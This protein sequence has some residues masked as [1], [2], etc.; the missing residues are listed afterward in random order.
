MTQDGRTSS[1]LA[2]R[3]VGSVGIAVGA[4]GGPQPS[5]SGPEP[6]TR[7]LTAQSAH[8][9]ASASPVPTELNTPCSSAR[10]LSP[11]PLPEFDDSPAPS[12]RNLQ[13]WVHTLASPALR[14]RE[15]G[16]SDSQRTALLLATYLERL[17]IAPGQSGDYCAP[18]ASATW[19]DQNVLAHRPPADAT[20]PWLVVGAHY[21]ALGTDERGQLFPGADD[22]ATG[23]AILLELAR[24]VHGGSVA[25]KLGLVLGFFGAEEKELAGSRAYVASPSVPLDRV[26]LMINVDMAGRKPRGHPVIGFEA[27]GRDRAGTSRALQAVAKRA[28]VSAVAMQLGERSDS[29]SFSPHVPSLFLCTT[30]HEDYHRPTDTADRVDFDQVER[31]L[32]LVIG[33]VRS[34]DCAR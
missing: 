10:G 8:P 3:L 18:F 28:R 23:V 34:L 27:F 33:L 12:R 13:T 15:A 9:V 1:R 24:L 17:G 20:C 29:A 11:L 16:T 30:V 5:P 22:N 26:A 2:L 32:A 4:C 7:V 21:D 25:P 31:T 19:R 6:P 14:G